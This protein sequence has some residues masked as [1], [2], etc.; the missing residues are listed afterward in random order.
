MKILQMIFKT[1]D[2]K[3]NTLKLNHPREDL[4]RETVERAMDQIAAINAFEKDGNPLYVDKH[5]ARY[6][7]TITTHLFDLDQE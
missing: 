7:E 2:G 3:N 4:D 6:V 5:A 1:A